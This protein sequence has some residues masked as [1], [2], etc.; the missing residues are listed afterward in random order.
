MFA[1]L[2]WTRSIDRKAQPILFDLTYDFQL[3]DAT[4]NLNVEEDLRSKDLVLNWRPALKME[5]VL[6]DLRRLAL[7]SIGKQSSSCFVCDTQHVQLLRKRS[8][9]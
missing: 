1:G 8:L 4:T 2:T 3:T 5:H 9:S 7:A 6:F